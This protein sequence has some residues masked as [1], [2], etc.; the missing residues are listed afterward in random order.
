MFLLLLK[1]SQWNAEMEGVDTELLVISL[2]PMETKSWSLTALGNALTRK[3][4]AGSSL[5]S[6]QKVGSKPKIW[7]MSISWK[8]QLHLHRSQ[9]LTEK[10]FGR[11]EAPG[12]GKSTVARNLTKHLWRLPGTPFCLIRGYWTSNTTSESNLG[13]KFR[14]IIFNSFYFIADI[15]KDSKQLVSMSDLFFK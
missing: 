3:Y 12:K 6:M 5:N 4:L 7:E 15:S 10:L 9:L 14:E 8:K 1:W 2:T 11:M 13:L